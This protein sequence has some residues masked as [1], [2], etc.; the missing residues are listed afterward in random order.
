MGTE[1][2]PRGMRLEAQGSLPTIYF[3]VSHISVQF[4]H[5]ASAKIVHQAVCQ[6]VLPYIIFVSQHRLV[7][8][9]FFLI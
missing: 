7:Q 5:C 2:M 9:I 8:H 4:L 1:K 6:C 3:Y